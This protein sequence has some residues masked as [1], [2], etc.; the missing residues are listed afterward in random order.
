VLDASVAVG[1]DDAEESLGDDS[2]NLTSSDLEMVDDGGDQLVGVR[3]QDLVIPPGSRITS[4]RLQFTAAA[5]H[6]GDADLEIRAQRGPASTFRALDGDLS[7]RPLTTAMVPWPVPGWTGGARGPEQLTPDLSALVQ[8]LVDDA[9]WPGLG[10]IAFLIGGSGTRN[11]ESFNGDPAQAA[12]LHIELQIAECADG[13][14]NDDDGLIDYQPSGGGD[15]NCTVRWDT[16][17]A[18]APS[19]SCGMGPELLVLLPALLLARRRRHA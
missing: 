3:F 10:S 17:E 19:N 16:K 6:S 18:A 7:G 8:E 5:S 9:S 4:A 11:A 12:S 2:V 13:L 1:S 14:D 15:P